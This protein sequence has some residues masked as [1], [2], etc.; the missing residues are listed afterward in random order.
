MSAKIGH[1]KE[2]ENIILKISDLQVGYQQQS[3][4]GE[5]I[6]YGPLNAEIH[7]PEMIGIIGRNGIGKST[8]LRTLTG[9][10]HAIRGT[11]IIR[12]QE[13]SKISRSD[14]ARLISYVS[15][16]AINVQNL[17]VKELVS[18]GRFPY[19]NWF[20]K[21]TRVDHDIIDD[22]VEQ[23]GISHLLGKPVYQL[24]DGERQKVMIARALAQ[25][26]PV[27]ILDEPTA[28]LDLPARHET[29][30]LLNN[31]SRQKNKLI[32][33][34]T[35]DL[36]IA[37]DEVDKLWLM[38]DEGMLEGAPEDLLMNQGF[39]KLFNNSD[40]DFDARSLVFRFSRD[41]KKRVKIVADEKYIIFTRK[42]MERIGFKTTKNEDTDYTITVL[43]DNS[44]PV[45][46]VT[47]PDLKG[48][49]NSIYQLT[50]FFRHEL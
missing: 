49:F 39:R 38:T 6:V 24:S 32:I 33:F 15:T 18:M 11:V 17:R 43:C 26:T 36:S 5:G 22:S 21:L 8:L 3:N 48:S 1:M 30:R 41:L 31:L 9:I 47:A 14:R 44:T 37:M 46:Q 50:S 23:T 2:A 40:L 45:W 12:G 29:I 16:E 7:T 19:T 42:A 35:H 4:P 34:S 28:F 10:Q 13:I 27:I 20:G 25:D